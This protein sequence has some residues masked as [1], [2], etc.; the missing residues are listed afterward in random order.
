MASIE[1]GLHDLHSRSQN[2]D[3]SKNSSSSPSVDERSSSQLRNLSSAT[4]ERPFARI[5]SVDSG[6]PAEEAGLLVGDQIQLFG[7]VHA[8]NRAE[9]QRVAEVVQRHEG[10]RFSASMRF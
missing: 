1:I 7:S 5:S 3:D 9:L 6:S 2:L 4:N 8:R 10:V